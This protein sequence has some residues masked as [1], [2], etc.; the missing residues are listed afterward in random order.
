M[1]T[2]SEKRNREEFESDRIIKS[3]Y[4]TEFDSRPITDHS[5]MIPLD[6]N[7]ISVK[8]DTNPSTSNINSGYTFS[9]GLIN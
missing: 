7:T 2:S 8:H 4:D 9:F 5:L 3:N 6:S 1:T